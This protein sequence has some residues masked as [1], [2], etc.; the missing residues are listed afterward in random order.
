MPAHADVFSEESMI[1]FVSGP[2]N[3]TGPFLGG[4]YAV[5][6]K[7]PVTGGWNDANSGGNFGP[8]MRKSGFDGVFVKG[9]SK[10]PVYIFVDNG[11]AE[12]RDATGLWRKTVSETEASLKRN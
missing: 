7:S 4:R 10:K 5:V 11:K 3:G 1:G 6:S 9:I 8:L 2:A 12:L